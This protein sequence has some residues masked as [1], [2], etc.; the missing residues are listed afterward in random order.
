MLSEQLV[1]QQKFAW[2]V[3]CQIYSAIMTAISVYAV[4][5]VFR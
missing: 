2:L 4:H 1:V 5:G 3:G